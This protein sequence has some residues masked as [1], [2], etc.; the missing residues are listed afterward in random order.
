MERR[1]P[2]RGC[3]AWYRRRRSRVY[4]A[5][6]PGRPKSRFNNSL[7][8]VEERMRNSLA[9]ITVCA[10]LV[11]A[12]LVGGFEMQTQAQPGP[13]AQVPAPIPPPDTA[14]LRAQYGKWRTE[15]KTWGRGAPLG[16][17]VKGTPQLNRAGQRA[18]VTEMP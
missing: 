10:S 7:N 16:Q 3:G 5:R 15:F 6:I 2:Y 18:R 8:A 12:G 4:H 17:G 14:A 1:R 13:T 9:S 11:M